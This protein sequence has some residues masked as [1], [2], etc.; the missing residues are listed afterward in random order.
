MWERLANILSYFGHDLR[1]RDSY[2]PPPAGQEHSEGALRWGPLYV[3]SHEAVQ[4]FAAIG[5]T[6]SG[7]STILRLLLQD[8][9]PTI[10][11]KS[12]RRMLIFDPKRDVIPMLK[13]MAPDADIIITHPFDRRGA[14]WDISADCKE[15]RVAIELA[16]TLIPSVP[17][18]QPFFSDA[19]RHLLAGVLISYMWRKLDFSFAD[20]LRGLSSVR[21]M[22]RV[23]LACPHTRQL[24]GSYF[25]DKKLAGNILSTIATRL[26]AFQPIAACWETA[27][28]K[29]SIS[30]WITSERILVL[31]SSE[32]STNTFLALNS[33]LFKRAC[34]VT[35]DQNDSQTRR[36]FFIIEEISDA[37]KLLSLASL[38][39]R[40]RSKGACT[41]LS[42]QSIEGLKHQDSFG[43]HLAADILGQVGYRFIGRLECP[44]TAAWVSKLIGDAEV[45][46][47]T[48]S[49]TYSRENSVTHSESIVIKPALLPSEFMG[50]PTCSITNGLTGY[51]PCRNQ[52]GVIYSTLPGRD[53]FER[54]L[55]PP[56]DDVPGFL[57]RPPESQYLRD[58]TP[59]EEAL[60]CPSHLP[61]RG[62]QEQEG[63]SH[64]RRT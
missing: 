63:R 58:W 55:I 15:P 28:E 16:F 50:I 4:H 20:V 9:V 29:F 60:L 62:A 39:K 23:L 57:P 44:E 56:A 51:Y 40:G 48:T 2:G 5:A 3:P 36:S 45:S 37:G 11:P 22:R 49:H 52:P 64:R 25:Y 38:A 6:G 26:L 41:A 17:E 59:A 24:V 18:S 8:V 1:R 47:V 14:A 13:G 53:L 19:A 30:E 7:K 46:Q 61:R 42:F 31:G 34:D 27:T 32:I 33:S 43:A 35:L 21:L 12:D 10:R 54:D